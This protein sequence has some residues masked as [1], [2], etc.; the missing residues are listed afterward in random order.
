LHR[1]PRPPV[2]SGKYAGSAATRDRCC[3]RNA[4]IYVRLSAYLTDDADSP[5]AE[6]AVNHLLGHEYGNHVQDL[7]GISA[8]SGERYSR[9][10]GAARLQ[11]NLSARVAG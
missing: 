3:G 1:S 4:T 10:E 11:E 2:T 5:Y 6:A 8:F 9:A 7:V